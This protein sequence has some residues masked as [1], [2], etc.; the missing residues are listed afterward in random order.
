MS[1]DETVTLSMKSKYKITIDSM[2]IIR[3]YFTTNED[4]INIMK[5]AKKY[6]DLVKMYHFNPISDTSL[7][8][9]METQYFYLPEITT[10]KTEKSK[11]FK[12]IFKKKSGKTSNQGYKKKGMKQYVYWYSNDELRK[13]LKSNEIMK[14]VNPY[15]YVV[16]NIDKLEEW[17]G[18]K[19]SSVLFDSEVDGKDSSIFRSKVLHQS[20]LYFII[21]DSDNNVFGH[22][23]SD[24]INLCGDFYKH[25]NQTNEF[26][27]ISLHSNG[28]CGMK[29]FEPKD[30]HPYTIIIDDQGYFGC[31]YGYDSE[32][33][34]YF[35]TSTLID[36][37]M[38]LLFGNNIVNVFDGI[39]EN[40][41]NGKY[42]YFTTKRIIV[43]QMK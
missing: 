7:F 8:V 30:D 15:K 23:H 35:Y 16:N 10:D 3:K 5:V 27:I 24:N 28:R 31:G 12:D 42:G 43:I 40:T 19:Y 29:K 38:S 11:S 25:Y 39:E 18:R 2:M 14:P 33:Y 26:F 36:F 21:I 41:L 34:F 37:N 4:F 17:S 20:H 9:T 32:H 6:Q 22:Y 13:N 1:R